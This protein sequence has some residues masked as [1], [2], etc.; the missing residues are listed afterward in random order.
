MM[1]RRLCQLYAGLT[2]Y[3][4]S[5]AMMVRSALGLNPWDVFHQGLG[6]RTPLSFGTVVILTGVVVLLLWIPLRQRPGLGTISNIIVIGLT[7]DLG[8]WLIPQVAGLPARGAVLAAGIVLC[9]VATSAYIGAGFGPGPRDGLMTGLANRTGWSIRAVR[10][11]IE[12]TALGLGWALGGTVGAGT[13]L[14]AVA[15]GPIVHATLPFFT[16]GS[17]APA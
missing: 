9:G 1:I 11:G 7:A 8:L 12:L 6:D 4:L 15:I 13:I 17:R 10:T 2:L 5:S 16:S 3:G 14:Y